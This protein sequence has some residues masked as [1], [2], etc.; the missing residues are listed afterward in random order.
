MFPFCQ[1]FKA[2]QWNTASLLLRDSVLC[3]FGGEY[4]YPALKENGILVAEYVRM[5]DE[6]SDTEILQYLRNFKERARSKSF[7]SLINR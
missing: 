2:Y 5:L 7:R 4:I 3:K 6:V 1:M